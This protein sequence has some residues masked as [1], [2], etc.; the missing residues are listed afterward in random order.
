MPEDNFQ[1]LQDGKERQIEL[2]ID[3]LAVTNAV[4]AANGHQALKR[5]RQT[6]KAQ[7]NPHHK[8][9]A[10]SLK[11]ECRRRADSKGV[12]VDPKNPKINLICS[13]CRNQREKDRKNYGRQLR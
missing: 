1:Q 8:A 2:G 10:K 7:G 13:K 4:Q 3:S 9:A 6:L 12:T 5:G 11:E